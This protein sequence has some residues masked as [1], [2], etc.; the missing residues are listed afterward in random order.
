MHRC[1][2]FPAIPAPGNGPN[3][4]VAQRPVTAPNRGS[5]ILRIRCAITMPIGP[6]TRN[7]PE[8][9]IW[10][11]CSPPAANRF[12]I[13]GPGTD[14]FPGS[15]PGGFQ[16]LPPWTSASPRLRSPVLLP[17][18]VMRHGCSFRI[19]RLIA[20]SVLKYWSIFGKW[21][22]R[23]ARLSVWPAMRLLSAC[24]SARIREL[25]EPPAGSAGK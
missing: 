9:R 23:A 20:S 19:T 13:L 18:P 25:D 11:D 6:A 3:P 10:C 21:R 15:L 14:S 24:R 22:R 7:W 5:A 8:Q 1:V 12:S 17:L 2:W 4:I 16:R